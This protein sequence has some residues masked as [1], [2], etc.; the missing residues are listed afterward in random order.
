RLQDVRFEGVD[1]R[2]SPTEWVFGRAV[3]RSYVPVLDTA[4]SAILMDDSYRVV[5]PVLNPREDADIVRFACAIA[6]ARDKATVHAVHVVQAPEN[7]SLIHGDT[8][9]RITETSER[10]IRD[11]GEVAE[12]YDVG[13]KASTLST[14][15]SLEEVFDLAKR[16]RPDLVVM[17]WGDGDIWRGARAERRID[18]LTN[19]LPCD[20]V[21]V[22]DRD[23]DASSLLLPT[24]GGTDSDLGGEV[25]CALHDVLDTEVHL[26]HV[27]ARES[28]RPHAES[29]L[30]GWAEK[31]HLEDAKKEVDT[32]GDVQGAIKRAA[33]GHTM[34]VL[35][36]TDKG[37]LS[38]LISRALHLEVVEDID[39]TVVLV[40]RPR[41]R[42]L[43]ERLFGAGTSASRRGTTPENED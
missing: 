25:A 41:E 39:A 4:E 13:F 23:L 21:V 7:I 10:L 6:S 34:V 14:H 3:G 26:L 32:S 19:R 38:R 33:E 15:R 9:Q 5:V 8:A 28:E 35:G 11:L 12:D 24:A 30:D 22:G 20:F 37:M 42:S 40:E 27:V 1:R 36:A 16:T 43:R 29:F 17:G 18:E 2:L 31:H